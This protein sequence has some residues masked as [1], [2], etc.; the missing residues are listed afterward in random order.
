MME[1]YFGG[2]GVLEF[3]LYIFVIFE[4]ENLDFYNEMCRIFLS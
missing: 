1:Y 4:I 3:I 2:W